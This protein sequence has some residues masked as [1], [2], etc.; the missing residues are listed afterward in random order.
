VTWPRRPHLRAWL[1]QVLAVAFML[2]AALTVT[3]SS[4]DATG[5]APIPATGAR[6]VPWASPGFGS[7][8]APELFVGSSNANASTTLHRP[9]NDTTAPSATPRPA[10][11]ALV[12]TWTRTHLT[13]AL[14]RSA[15]SRAPPL[16]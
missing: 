12:A 16:A 10:T 15:S 14:I 9:S 7:V 13:A 6:S 4:T 11:G 8:G 1:A 3:G 5:L 2:C